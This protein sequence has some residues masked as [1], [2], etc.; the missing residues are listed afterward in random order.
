VTDLG[1][2]VVCSFDG[3]VLYG[4]DNARPT[5]AAIGYVVSAGGPLVEGSRPLAAF[6][7]S[8]HVEYRA[9]VAAAR[10]VAALADHRS[11]ADVH[12]R[13][14]AD[15]VIQTVDPD[16]AAEP[17]DDVCRRR[18]ATVRELLAPFPTVSYRA[19]DRGRNHRAHALAARAHPTDETVSSPESEG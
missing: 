19:V 11:I 12:V 2:S 9:L 4:A 15:G 13:G 3:S 10:A 5:A 18:V 8:T 7:S 17:G 6:V 1:A 14:D 16:A